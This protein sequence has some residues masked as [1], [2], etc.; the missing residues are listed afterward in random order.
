MPPADDWRCGTEA[1]EVP[2]VLADQR[3]VGRN[4]RRITDQ[5]EWRMMKRVKPT[6]ASV[7]VLVSPQHAT[8]GPPGGG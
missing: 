3:I 6:T 5:A 7:T 8:G 2:S 1:G 4:G